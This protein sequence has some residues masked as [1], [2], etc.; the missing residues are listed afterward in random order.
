MLV[1]VTIKGK[2]LILYSFHTYRFLVAIQ[3]IKWRKIGT[4]ILMSELWLALNAS[5]EIFLYLSSIIR[6]PYK[7]PLVCNNL[8]AG[9]ISPPK[10]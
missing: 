7:Y 10:R 3:G 6:Q 1:T 4:P 2:F 8:C 9:F 5:T